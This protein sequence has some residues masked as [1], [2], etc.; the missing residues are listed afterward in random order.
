[1]SNRDNVR[2]GV[3]GGRLTIRTA[4][5]L[6]I[7]SG[8]VEGAMIRGPVPLAGALRGGLGAWAYHL[9]FASLF[10]VVGVGLWR[11]ARWGPLALYLAT[12]AYTVDKLRYLLDRP[13]REAELLH[14]LRNYP[15]VLDVFG[16]DP[17]LRLE[18]VFTVL[19][20]GCWLG[21]AAYI[22]VRRTYFQV[23]GRGPASKELTRP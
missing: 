14:Q 11:A 5:V 19:F 7:L 2:G 21:F 20:I 4:A 10:V 6:F 3:V 22:Y 23:S 16:L 15:D 9:A 18:T 13:A 17:L 1:V 12:A 8:L